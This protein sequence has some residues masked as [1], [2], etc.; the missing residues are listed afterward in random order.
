MDRDML[1]L[2]HQPSGSIADASGK[3][4]AGVENLR[5]GSAQ[6]R[7]AHLLDNRVQ[8][9]LHHRRG[10]RIDMSFHHDIVTELGWSIRQH[11]HYG[12]YCV[13]VVGLTCGRRDVH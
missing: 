13:G 6:H 10:D 8:P 12:H 1:G 7:L 4:A 5:V 9:V 11:M 3:I 2:C